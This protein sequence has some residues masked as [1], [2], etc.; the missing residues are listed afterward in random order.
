MHNAPARNPPYNE[1]MRTAGQNVTK[2]R[3]DSPI[4]GIKARRS[5]VAA[6]VA[7][8]ATPY[9]TGPDRFLEP[10]KRFRIKLSICEMQLVQLDLSIL[11]FHDGRVAACHRGAAQMASS[12]ASPRPDSAPR[13]MKLPLLLQRLEKTLF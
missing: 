10:V 6:T 4:S 1:T 5:S 8:T 9:F 13:N 11:R 3:P 2:G 7:S 12:R